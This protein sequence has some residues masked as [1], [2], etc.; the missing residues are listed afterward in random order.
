MTLVTQLS[1]ARNL[2]LGREPVKEPG[3]LNRLD[4]DKMN[5]V[6]RNLLDVLFPPK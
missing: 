5:E 6:A 1:I 2:F 3:V 4:Q